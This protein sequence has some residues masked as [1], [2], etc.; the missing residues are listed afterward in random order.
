MTGT[1]KSLLH[2]PTTLFN[3]STMSGLPGRHRRV[4]GRRRRAVGWGGCLATA[5][6]LIA[7][8]G[9]SQADDAPVASSGA[10]GG[11][12]QADSGAGDTVSG[13]AETNSAATVVAEPRELDQPVEIGQPLPLELARVRAHLLHETLHGALQ[14]MHRDF[15]KAGQS[16]KIPSHSLEDVFLELQNTH[17]VQLRWIAVNTKA[18]SIDNKPESEFELAAVEQLKKGKPTYERLDADRYQFA[19]AIRLSASCLACHLS[20]RRDNNDR[21]AG[22]VITIPAEQIQLPE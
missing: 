18:M 9:S 14:V 21:L 4:V 6:L 20:G 13:A 10:P 5:A 15:F 7:L 22:L 1:Y 11:V 8:T 17:G 19:G 2:W 3:L 12:T 16:L